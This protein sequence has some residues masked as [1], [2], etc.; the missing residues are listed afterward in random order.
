MMI[1]PTYNKQRRGFLLTKVKL[2]HLPF[3]ARFLYIFK[4]LF[5]AMKRLQKYGF[6]LDPIKEAFFTCCGKY[7][8]RVPSD[9][10]PDCW[11]QKD[12]TS[13]EPNIF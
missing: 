3:G 11:P 2:I 7:F 10:L 4:C 9:H 13:F 6:C 12:I 1:F 8:D 5:Q